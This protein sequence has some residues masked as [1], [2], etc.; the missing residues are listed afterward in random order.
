M[1]GIIEK[2]RKDFIYKMYF[3]FSGFLSKHLNENVGDGKIMDRINKSSTASQ[4]ASRQSGLWKN[5][6][7]DGAWNLFSS[8]FLWGRGPRGVIKDPFQRSIIW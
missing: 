3:F 8:F 4:R 2:N 7:M 5:L 1:L 6:C